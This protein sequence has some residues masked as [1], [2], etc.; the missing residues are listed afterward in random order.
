MKTR[1]LSFFLFP[2]LLSS[3]TV[4][5]RVQADEGYSVIATIPI[6]GPGGGVGVNPIPICST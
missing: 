3:F 6:G 2:F 1:I 4:C 5:T